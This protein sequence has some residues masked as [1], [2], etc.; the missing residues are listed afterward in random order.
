MGVPITTDLSAGGLT[1]GVALRSPSRGPATC[2]SS[3]ERF[4]DP[5]ALAI[6][7]HVTLLPPTEVPAAGWARSGTTS[8]PS[9]RP[10]AVQALLEGTDTFRPVSPVVF[11]RVAVGGEGCD[12]VQRAVRTGPLARDLTFPF[13]PHVT[14][15]HHLDDEA[16]DRA[17]RAWPTSR[18]RSSSTGSCSTSTGRTASGGPAAGS[19]SADGGI[20]G[21][22]MTGRR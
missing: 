14:V 20:D 15:A 4:G 18:R 13:H 8:T 3:R 22:A 2:S 11:V 1:I 7:A 9:R 10:W 6:P 12:C 16:L 21:P 17:M 19:G 5:Q